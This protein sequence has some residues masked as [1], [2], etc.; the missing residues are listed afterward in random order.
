MSLHHIWCL[1]YLLCQALAP[2]EALHGP[3]R[4]LAVYGGDTF[5]QDAP[6]LGAAM[7]FIKKK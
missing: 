7:H 4:W 6:D 5:I 1:L 3:G 2:I